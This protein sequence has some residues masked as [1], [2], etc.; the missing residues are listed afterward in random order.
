[1]ALTQTGRGA[2]L[3]DEKAC[4]DKAM[5]WGAAFTYRKLKKWH[6][7]YYG[8]GSQMGP[9]WAMWRYAINNA[10]E[11][12]PQY[13]QWY[14]Q[15]YENSLRHKEDIKSEVNFKDFLEDC[16]AHAKG[17]N[18]ILSR[19]AYKKFCEKYGLET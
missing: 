5:E 9:C 6:R 2:K 17:K 14:F 13:K 19:S 11:C 15:T 12:F 4:W 3:Y 1:M 7:D 18:T 16:K 8:F 10:E